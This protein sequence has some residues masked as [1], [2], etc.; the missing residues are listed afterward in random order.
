MLLV[1]ASVR[2]APAAAQVD[3]SVGVGAGTVRYPGGTSFGSAI[4]SPG[5]RYTSEALVADV[6]AGLASL[7]HKPSHRI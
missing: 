2:A 6:S 3:G 5:V 4:L 1:A 7:P